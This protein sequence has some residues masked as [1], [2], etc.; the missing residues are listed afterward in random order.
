MRC[1]LVIYQFVLILA[2]PDVQESYYRFQTILA[3]RFIPSRNYSRG[4][5]ILAKTN[6]NLKK[7]VDRIGTF[8]SEARTEL[9][10]KVNYYC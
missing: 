10:N 6:P 1:V 5:D 9:S 7:E 8:F 2:S 3:A 4:K